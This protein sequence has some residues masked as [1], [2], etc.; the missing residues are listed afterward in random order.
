MR[1][2]TSATKDINRK[3]PPGKVL[4]MVKNATKTDNMSFG[5]KSQQSSNSPSI[6]SHIDRPKIVCNP[7]GVPTELHSLGT[8]VNWHFHARDDDWAKV[9][10]RF[11]Y[12]HES[13]SWWIGRID[14]LDRRS[15]LSFEDAAHWPFLHGEL[16]DRVSIGLGLVL[17]ESDPYTFIDLDD[18]RDPL[19]GD[20]T[21][22]AVEIIER[23]ASYT[24]VS[25]SGTGVKIFIRGRKPGRRCRTSAR[26]GIELYDQARF[27]AITGMP[28]P[29]TPGGIVDRQAELDAFYAELFPPSDS[30]ISE[31]ADPPRPFIRPSSLTDSE[32]ISRILAS[33]G[34]GRFRSLWSGDPSAYAHADGKPDHS[35]ADFALAGILAFWCGPDPSRIVSLMRQSG[36]VRDKWSRVGYLAD[37]VDRAIQGTPRYFG[38][39]RPF[40][41]ST[42]HHK[43]F[44][45]FDG[46]TAEDI[47][48]SFKRLFANR[49]QSPSSPIPASPIV[50]STARDFS[51]FATPSSPIVPAPARPKQSQAVA[52]PTC[53]FFASCYHPQKMQMEFRKLLCG[54]WC[55]PHCG[56]ALSGK[57]KA[58][59]SSVI[60]HMVE[61]GSGK[62]RSEPVYVGS[63][64]ANSWVRIRKQIQ[65]ARGG[66]GGEFIRVT[67]TAGDQ[68]VCST[69]PFEGST[70]VEPAIAAV[71]VGVAI[72]AVPNMAGQKKPISTS[73]KWRLPVPEASGWK[74]IDTLPRDAKPE[75]IVA[76][77]ESRGHS[78]ETRMPNQLF[79]RWAAAIALVPHPDESVHEAASRIHNELLADLYGLGTLDVD[80]GDVSRPK[81]SSEAFNAGRSFAEELNSR[82]AG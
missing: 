82:L 62:L 68:T 41:D 53:G 48:E 63:V 17:T 45:D 52:Q 81:P 5:Q 35:A 51:E 14:H 30:T 27:A 21:P 54:R 71:R 56:Q 55:C 10:R 2:T 31:S 40:G 79:F 28:V 66:R 64:N 65:R 25:N 22:W 47:R 3:H 13:R 69:V 23:F 36:L 72:K 38:D 73:E 67:F 12:C 4:V 11:V 7:G 70:P 24:E 29:G 78:V 37:T 80:W 8:W 58:H 44:E 50:V 60:T 46:M 75:D 19:S 59:S 57:W 16:F 20:L 6:D 39:G 18:C 43:R 26:P 76:H 34:G 32:L 15:W 74:R 77:L 1:N 61:D 49:Q 33:A 42:E 9:P